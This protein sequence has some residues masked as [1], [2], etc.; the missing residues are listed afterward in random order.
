[1]TPSTGHLRVAMYSHD[2]YGLG[3]LTRTARIA[4]GVVQAFPGSSV[5]ILSGSPIAH[6][7]T[8]PA[9]VD[10]VKLPA[11]VK[12]GPDTYI[13]R[14][15][16][17]SHRGIRRMRA[18]LILD[19]VDHFRPHLFLVDN[20]PL[21]MKGELLPTLKK[22]RR[23]RPGTLVHLNL[24]DILDDPETIR[25]SWR[26]LGVHDLLPR[27]YDAIHVFGSQS[28]FD[29]VAAY[30]LPAERAA[31]LGYIGPSSENGREAPVLPPEEPGRSRV[32]VTIGG[33]GDGVEIL[34]CAG[35]LQRTLGPISP[36]QFHIV[37]GPLMDPETRRG[38]DR[39]L[40]GVKGITFHDYV[41]NLPGWMAQCDLVLSMGGY[42]TLCEVM[43]VA[44]RIVVVPRIYP[45]R[46]Q[47]IRARAFETRGL[48]RVLHPNDL[49]VQGLDEA[50]RQSLQVDPYFLSARRP[51]LQGI[52][53][54]QQRL[55]ELLSKSPPPVARA[56][57]KNS[58]PEGGQGSA[59]DAVRVTPR[60]QRH[61]SSPP[62]VSSRPSA[63]RPRR[64]PF[65][66]S[67][68]ALLALGFGTGAGAHLHPQRVEA[69]VG[70]GYDTNLLNASAAERRAFEENDPQAFFSVNRMEDLFWIGMIAADWKL[71]R[72]LG[73]KSKLRARYERTQF[74]YNPI[75][76]EDGYG[77]ALQTKMD[78]RTRVAFQL[79]LR[80]QVYG[81][82]RMD[83]DAQPGQPQF[84]AEVHRRWDAGVGVRRALGRR[85][86]AEAELV[87][88]VKDYNGLFNERDRRR[89]GIS[90]G[91]GWLANRTLE[92][93]FEGGFRRTWSRNKPDLGKDLS[94]REWIAEPRIRFGGLAV[95]SELEVALGLT[96]RRY[97]S[98][99]PG[100]WNHCGRH[101]LMRDLLVRLARSLSAS[102]A[103]TMT[104]AARWRKARLDS[105][106]SV[107]YD[108]DGSFSE[109]VF[110]GGLNWRWEP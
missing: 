38:L 29:S 70:I 94:C 84:R 75:K 42:N 41:E 25:R 36:F 5:L 80:P 93:R 69:S 87:G 89:V 63:R 22:L 4:Q 2:T 55:G 95:F 74:L 76:S 28:I 86:E 66:G 97:T 71:G 83:K 6:R 15:L 12:S 31:F 20:V 68:L 48:L 47:E 33:G 107:D 52:S 73:L 53:R 77:L 51:P 16:G 19:A 78:R 46:E 30:D 82:H 45:R 54:L 35:E 10:Y 99:D 100:D 24:R 27:F 56:T 37:T 1:M 106:L 88:S 43:A 92:L 64:G 65:L 103:L 60:R 26:K 98:E 13:A 79:G 81:R 61:P 40:A 7:F 17:M 101:D 104:Y 102:T 57:G 18:Q 3:H 59:I 50:L 110:T 23:D 67:L 14:E 105:G 72:P 9:G 21:G 90:A 58:A 85:W 39:D 11:V 8:F 44:Q 34:R 32:L 96:W 49:N 91:M 109:N 108:E 62:R